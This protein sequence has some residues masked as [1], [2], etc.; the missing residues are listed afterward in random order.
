MPRLQLPLA[1]RPAVLW[2]LDAEQI[3]LLVT[4]SEDD[5][6]IRRDSGFPDAWRKQPYRSKIESLAASREA[7]DV[8]VLVI[9]G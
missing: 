7:Y 1:D 6:E 3:K 4:S 8:S 2:A 9:D 5:L